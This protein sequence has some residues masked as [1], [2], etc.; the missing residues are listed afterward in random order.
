M[1]ALYTDGLDVEIKDC[2][3]RVKLKIIVGVMDLPAKAE[4]LH[5]SYFNGSFPC[6]T[7]EEEG[8]TVKQ[9]KG[10]AKCLPY[11]PPDERSMHRS[12][13]TVLENMRAGRPNTRVKG[14]KGESGLAHLADFNIV[15]GIVP[16]YMHG[17]CLG[18]TKTL[19][20]KWFSSKEKKERYC[21]GDHI[22]EISKVM[23]H[24]KP[25]HN[26]ERL[27]RNL[28]KH[29]QHF[30][31]TEMQ[32]W[33]LYYA[34]PCVKDFLDD[35]YLENLLCLSEGIHILLGESI[36]QDM[37]TKAEGLLQRFY[38]SFPKLYGRGSCG[39]NVHNIGTH[40]CEFVKL[41]GPLWC[42]SCFPFEDINAM[43]LNAVHGTGI[44]L[45][46]AMKYRQAQLCIRI[47]NS[48]VNNV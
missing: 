22:E 34:Y 32:T 42:W 12:Q 41:W 11:K 20:S 31:A 8:T 36:S 37:L 9:G 35:D 18:V 46:Q 26:I 21:I 23:E 10:S 30:K 45:K 19:M 25:P 47:Q 33:L 5:M 7:C 40:L 16:D 3:F 29:Y 13:R 27:P 43:L 6:I 4:L 28:E 38:E 44:V 14:F 1:N 39:L 2:C 48:E 17:V 15:S 24:F